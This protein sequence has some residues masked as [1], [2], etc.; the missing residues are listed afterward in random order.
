M[1]PIEI[2]TDEYKRIEIPSGMRTEVD[3]G[4]G[5]GKFSLELSELMPSSYII[6]ADIML[7]RLRKVAKKAE[8]LKLKNFRI[9]RTEATA[10]LGYML[11]DNTVDRVHI[12]CPDP[13]PKTKHKGHR[14]LSSQFMA[15]ICRVLKPGGI[16]HFSTD[17]TAYLNQTIEN[18][19]KSSL[20]YS[21]NST[22]IEDV[23]NIKTAFELKWQ[24]EGLK[25]HHKAWQIK[26]I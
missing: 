3:L 24:E 9:L 26:K 1:Y 2:L 15:S 12:L 7:G 21:H 17:N 10:L 19:E 23:R 13:W 8:R 16:F 20:F 11:K 14:L 25:V 18:I 4:C 22:L 5:N 6:A